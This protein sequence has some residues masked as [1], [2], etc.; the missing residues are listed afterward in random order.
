VKARA[1]TPSC[2]AGQEHACSRVSFFDPVPDSLQYCLGLSVF[3][4]RTTAWEFVCPSDVPC[5]RSLGLAAVFPWLAFWSVLLRRQCPFFNLWFCFF[6]EQLS[7]VVFPL[8]GQWI[9]CA[10]F[11]SAL[12]R[13]VFSTCV[14]LCVC[15][16][17]EEL[18][19]I[20]KYFC[21]AVCGVKANLWG[22]WRE[23]LQEFV[24][25]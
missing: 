20:A 5:V 23:L 4:S 15:L 2:A 11:R 1:G 14:Q 16:P 25:V 21:L 13:G 17:L 19:A 7:P 8:P 22:S 10:G 3:S 6:C 12:A 9:S 18:L 24:S